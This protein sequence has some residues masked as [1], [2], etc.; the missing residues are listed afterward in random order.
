[1]QHVYHMNLHFCVTNMHINCCYCCYC[2]Y[3]FDI[4]CIILLKVWVWQWVKFYVKN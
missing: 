3:W 4:I 1:V 2:Y